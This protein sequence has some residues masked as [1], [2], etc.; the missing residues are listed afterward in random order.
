MEEPVASRVEHNVSIPALADQFA[1]KKTPAALLVVD[2][3]LVQCSPDSAALGGLPTNNEPPTL[4]TP[5]PNN[6]QFR[7]DAELGDLAWRFDP[8]LGMI[9]TDEELHACNS[10]LVIVD[11]T[12]EVEHNLH[13]GR[14]ECYQMDKAGECEHSFENGTELPNFQMNPFVSINYP[15]G[16][17]FFSE[18]LSVV[19]AG[20][21][22]WHRFFG[23]LI[24]QN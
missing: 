7:D 3:S 5:I 6:Q 17:D 11:S 16:R 9:P 19:R 22:V 23:A 15:Q 24:Y 12:R 20:G 8:E 21:D 2:T 1:A 13:A 10:R 4:D 14:G 18:D